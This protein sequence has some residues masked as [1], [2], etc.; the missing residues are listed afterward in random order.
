[1]AKRW[2]H[3]ELLERIDA[4]GS[5][6]AAASA[7]GMS[8]KAAWQAV[9]GINNLSHEPLVVRQ[10]GGSTGGGT[11]SDRIRTASGCHLSAAGTGMGQRA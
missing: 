2:D 3:L 4:S 6:S 10:P 7:M 5:I 11:L 1:V 8:Y 9:E